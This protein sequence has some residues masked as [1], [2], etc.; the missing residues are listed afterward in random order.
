M[1]WNKNVNEGA[2][3]VVPK[4]CRWQLINE[5]HNWTIMEDSREHWKEQEQDTDFVKCAGSV[6]VKILEAVM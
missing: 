3:W 5:D 4:G 6:D 1:W 2:G